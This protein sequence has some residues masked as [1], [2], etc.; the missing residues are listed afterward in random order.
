M[1]SNSLWQQVA[2]NHSTTLLYANMQIYYVYINACS[3]KFVAMAEGGFTGGLGG[4]NPQTS[5]PTTPEEPPPPSQKKLQPPPEMTFSAN[6]RYYFSKNFAC[7]RLLFFP[8][9]EN[10]FFY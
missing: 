2:T 6:R 3:I 1:D 5:A 10:A 8:Y 7:G 4:F 9:Y